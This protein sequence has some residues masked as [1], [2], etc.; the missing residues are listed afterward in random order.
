MV[1]GSKTGMDRASQRQFQPLREM[2]HKLYPKSWLVQLNSTWERACC[3]PYMM[4]ERAWKMALDCLCAFLLLHACH[5]PERSY[6]S[7]NTLK[8]LSPAHCPWDFIPLNCSFLI[9]LSMN[10][11]NLLW[12]MGR[13]TRSGFLSSWAKPLSSS[14]LCWLHRL[15]LC[16]QFADMPKYPV[17]SM[18][19][20]VPVRA[21]AKELP[22]L[23]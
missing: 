11:A 4:Q 12:H 16:L 18:L 22:W 1:T 13:K 14:V 7:L 23:M 15:F 6:P 10:G 3:V 5:P 8:V 9:L 20:T 17:E 2:L 21:V 19:Q